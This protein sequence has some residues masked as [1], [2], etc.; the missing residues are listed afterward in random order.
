[1][2]SLLILLLAA[3]PAAAEPRTEVPAGTLL[4]VELVDPVHSGKNKA[5]DP[6]RARLSEGVWARGALA[7]P[8]GTTVRGEL[9]EAAP[10]GR[11]KGRARLAMTLRW[12]ELDGSSHA[13]KTDTLR[14]EGDRHA[15][16]NVGAW[17]AGALQGALYGAVFGGKEGAVI[18]AGAGAGAGAAAGAIK[19]RQDVEFPAGAK[20]M[21]ETAEALGLPAVPAPAAAPKAAEEKAPKPSS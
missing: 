1:M 17:L 18:G 5:G 10:S 14:Y 13:V 2:K 9:V 21:F 12:I 6:F 4:A 11:L 19:G 16:K 8:P 3:A 20:I 7:L 15:G